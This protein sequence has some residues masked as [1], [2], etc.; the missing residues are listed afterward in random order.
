[1]TEERFESLVD[2]WMRALGEWRR[3]RLPYRSRRTSLVEAITSTYWMFRMGPCHCWAFGKGFPFGTA[4]L[5]RK[6]HPLLSRYFGFMQ[7]ACRILHSRRDYYWKLDLDL[8]VFGPEGSWP[9][10][11]WSPKMRNREIARLARYCV[12]LLRGAGQR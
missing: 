9:R 10:E 6:E 5:W 2:R 7:A 1:M 3:D 4:R 8:L 11:L 12:K